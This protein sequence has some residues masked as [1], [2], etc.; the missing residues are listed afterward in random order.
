MMSS[1]TL[2]RILPN[3]GHGGVWGA[4]DDN[5]DMRNLHSRYRYYD[6]LRNDHVE[7]DRLWTSIESL[8]MATLTSPHI[9]P[10]I[11]TKLSSDGSGDTSS[12]TIE[13]TSST[14]PNLVRSW[15]ADTN[16]NKR[17][18]R[19]D[20][21]VDGYKACSIED[22]LENEP[23]YARNEKSEKFQIFILVSKFS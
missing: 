11:T 12:T 5:G 3:Q 18:W 2:L 8:F 1:K 22:W 23:S 4:W 10:E 21:I 16:N 9:I 17:E 6:A 15:Q 20:F 13:M 14:Q 19:R 7:L